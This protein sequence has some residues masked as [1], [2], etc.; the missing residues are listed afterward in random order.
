MQY[1]IYRFLFNRRLNPR[2]IT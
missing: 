1:A 2:M